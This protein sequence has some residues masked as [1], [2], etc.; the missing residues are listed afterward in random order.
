MRLEKEV[1]VKGYKKKKEIK[2]A[3]KERFT[4]KLFSKYFFKI[5]DG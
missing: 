5:Y 1:K 4:F 3:K 2:K